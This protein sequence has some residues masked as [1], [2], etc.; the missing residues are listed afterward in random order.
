MISARFASTQE[1][2]KTFLAQ[3]DVKKKE[4]LVCDLLKVFR[5][6]D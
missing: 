3:R 2:R 4:K 1:R 6:D 5:I